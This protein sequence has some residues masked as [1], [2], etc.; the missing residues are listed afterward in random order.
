MPETPIPRTPTTV[1]GDVEEPAEPTAPL[2]PHRLCFLDQLSEDLK[3]QCQTLVILDSAI[4]HLKKKDVRA[5]LKAFLTPFV[6]RGFDFLPEG[7]RLA[8]ADLIAIVFHET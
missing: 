5:D 7:A 8:M 2:A 4:E 6:A 1:A 3:G